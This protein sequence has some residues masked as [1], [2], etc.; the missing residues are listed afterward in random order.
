MKEIE[1]KRIL[2]TGGTGS[3]GTAL[4][5]RLLSG[6][7]G[8]PSRVTV[9]SRGELKQSQ[10]HASFPDKRLNLIIGDVRDRHA[11]ELALQ[12]TDVIINAAAMKRVETCE[13]NPAEAI[14]TNCL[15]T[16]N[17]VETIQKYNLPVETMVGISSDKGVHPV[18]VYGSTKM[19]QEKITL[20]GNKVIPGTRFIAVCYG[21]VMGSSGSVIPSFQA[22]IQKGKPL[23]IH[24]PEMTRFLISLDHAVDTILEALQYAQRGEIYVPILPAATVG[25]IADVII[26]DKTVEKV[27]IGRG[28][29]EK[30][31]ETLINVIE[32]MC[33]LKRGDYYVVSP[34]VQASPAIDREY[35]SCDYLISKS[36]LKELFKG[37]G[38]IE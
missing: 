8:N 21:N 24:D 16:I 7:S 27:T 10:L 30:I 31:D 26:G 36:E 13:E 37:H 17:I 18:N 20:A 34:E 29:G 23:T 32:V 33:T 38:F 11:I 35:V 3:L 14:K 15:G 5:E 9:F 19:I 12:N 4:V 2:I 1:G 25:D 22:L 28:S 6:V